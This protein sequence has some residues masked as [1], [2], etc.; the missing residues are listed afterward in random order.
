MT[1]ADSTEE[2]EQV[3][4]AMSPLA[5]ERWEDGIESD[6]VCISGLEEGCDGLSTAEVVALSSTVLARVC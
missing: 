1:M 4:M 6:V 2:A 5:M 3:G